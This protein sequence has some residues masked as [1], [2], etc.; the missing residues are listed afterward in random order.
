MTIIEF[1]QTEPHA[2]IVVANGGYRL[3]FENGD[4]VVEVLQI[5]KRLSRYPYR[6]TDESVAIEILQK[7]LADGSD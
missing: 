1:L 7:E 4:W 6:G 2:R 5:G 3:Y